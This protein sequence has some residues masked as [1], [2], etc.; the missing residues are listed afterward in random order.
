MSLDLDTGGTKESDET[1][2]PEAFRPASGPASGEIHSMA[3]A[4]VAGVTALRIS[5]S[6][7]SVNSGM[8]SAKPGASL[9]MLVIC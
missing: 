7:A 8:G 1:F 6:S 4:R 3:A 5:K 9:S 2:L